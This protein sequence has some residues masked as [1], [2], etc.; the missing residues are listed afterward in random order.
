MLKIVD[1]EADFLV[2]T[3]ACK[4][5]LGGV[6]MQGGSVVCYE[7]Q[8]LNEHKVNYVTHDLELA[9]IVHALKM[10]RHYLLGKFV[11]MIDHCGL[12]YMFDQ[13]NLNGRQARWMALL[14][15]FDFEIK[16]IKGKENRVVDALSRSMKIIHLAAVS[17]C[18]SDVK[19]RFKNE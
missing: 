14:S 1:P 4:E 5:G 13:P 18:E 15:E 8:K 10:W 9:A 17:T 11:L 19:E 7:S 12:Q 16:H 6:L 3:D 2:C